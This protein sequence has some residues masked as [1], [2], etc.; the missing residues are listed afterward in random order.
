MEVL[1]S[2]PVSLKLP[3]GSHCEVGLTKSC[4]GKVI[5]IDKGWPELMDHYSLVHG[6]LLVFRYEENSR[7][8]VLI[9]DT[10]AMEIG[11]SL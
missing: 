2:N 4:D 9:F 1:L 8:N 10:S 11:L 7:F 3:Y 6:H 5:W